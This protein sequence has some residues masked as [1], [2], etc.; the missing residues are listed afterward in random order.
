MRSR[1]D[2]SAPARL[3]RWEILGAW[4]HV[5]TA[6]KG[7]EVPPVPWRKV[8]LYGLGAAA[9]IGV[10][11]ALILPPLNDAKRKGEATRAR[12]AAAL[13][14]AERARLRADQRVHALQ[15]TSAAGAPVEKALVA[16]LETAITADARARAK[17][18][19]IKGPVLGT[20][21]EAGGKALSVF[22][23]SRVYKCFVK[24]TT[25]QPGQGGDVLGTGYPFVA[26]VY[27]KAGRVAWCKENPKPDEKGRRLLGV[28]VSPVCAG[29]LSAIL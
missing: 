5:W 15:V 1:A 4:L 26:T 13:L 3:T 21:C 7:L 11:L 22:P 24:T 19:T 17:R 28:R 8:L 16:A 29:K 18:G 20:A 10:A 9:V 12:E 6:P 2:S 14:A 23:Q 27:T 25:G